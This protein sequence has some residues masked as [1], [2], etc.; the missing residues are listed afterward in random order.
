[1]RHVCKTVSGEERVGNSV[2]GALFRKSRVSFALACSA[3]ALALLAC[4]SDS[5]GNNNTQ[6]PQQDPEKNVEDMHY[7]TVT[8]NTIPDEFS[9]SSK[10]G[11][12][13]DADCLKGTFC[14]HGTCAAQ[15]SESKPCADGGVCASNGICV[16]KNGKRD[17][18]NDAADTTPVEKTIGAEVVTT[19]PSNI[20]VAAGATSVP[21]EVQ[22]AQEVGLVYYTV[23]SSVDAT[24]DDA[25]EI[26]TAEPV[27]DSQTGIAT[28]TF[29][30]TPQDSSLGDVGTPEEV[31]IDT[32]IGSWSLTLSPEIHM[33]GLY[34]GG[35]TAAR[36][37]GTTLPVR[38]AIEVTPKTAKSF[39]EIT[40]MTLYM[41]ISQSDLFSPESPRA[42]ETSWS[43]IEM[44]KSKSNNISGEPSWVATYASNDFVMPGAELLKSADKVN[45]AIRIEI[46]D[47][48]K[49]SNAFIGKIQ[50]TF[51]GIYRVTDEGDTPDW[52]KPQL[53]GDLLL[54]RDSNFD[55]AGTTN[56]IITHIAAKEELRSRDAAPNYVCDD[57][58][59]AT[60]MALADDESCKAI[61]T[62]GGYELAANAQD[63]LISASD[64]IL[65]DDNLISKTIVGLV[66]KKADDISL[67]NGYQSLKDFLAACVQPNGVCAERPELVCAA[68]LLSR[69]YLAAKDTS[70]REDLLNKWYAMLRESYLGPQFAAWQ[71]DVEVRQQWLEGGDE[72]TFLVKVL[73]GWN[74][75]VL[76]GWE[77]DVL[78]AHV[79]VM[80][81]QITQSALEV[82]THV[83][84]SDEVTATREEILA[85]YADA[86]GGLSDAL[87]LGLRRYD[88]LVTKTTKRIEKATEMWPHVFD[89]YV[90]GLVAAD[91]NEKNNVTSLSSAYGKSLYENVSRLKMLGQS[92]DDLVFMRDA[93]VI[94]NTSL[95][96]NDETSGFTQRKAAA[97]KTLNE[98]RDRYT[99]VT[100]DYQNK[101]INSSQIA[102]TLDN[103]IDSLQRELVTL[104]GLPQGCKTATAKNCEPLVDAGFC[105]FDLAWDSDKPGSL[106]RDIADDSSLAKDL[107]ALSKD[108]YDIY[109]LTNSSEAATAILAYRAAI[110]DVDVARADYQALE[111]KV[112]TL[113]AAAQ[114]YS[115]NLEKWNEKR[116]ELIR[117]IHANIQT[118][119]EH[120]D[121][122]TQAEQDKLKQELANMQSIYD[123][124]AAN[125]TKWEEL[126]STYQTEQTRLINKIA[127][128]ESSA[129][130]M[131]FAGDLAKNV[132]DS[133]AEGFDEEAKWGDFPSITSSLKAGVSMVGTIAWGAFGAIA[134][135]CEIAA[136]QYQASSDIKSLKFELTTEAND[137]KMELEIAELELN[138]QKSFSELTDCAASE[139][140]RES[141]CKVVKTCECSEGVDTS[142]FHEKYCPEHPIEGDTTKTCAVE[143]KWYKMGLDQWIISEQ[144][145][146]DT[147]DQVNDYMRQLFDVNDRYE[148]D[149]QSL[150]DRRVEYLNMAED[151]L[152]KRQLIYKAQVAQYQALKQYYVITQRAQLLKSQYQ[153]AKDRKQRIEN[154]Y[155]TP[156][157]IFAYASDLEVVEAKLELAKE[158]IYDYLAAAEYY[159]VRPFVDLRR[160]TY[161][162]RSA[163]D[164]EKIIDQVDT[165][166]TKCGGNVSTEHVDVSVRQMMGITSELGDMKLGERF[167]QALVEGNVPVNSLTRYTVDTD[168]RTLLKR[169]KDLRSSTFEVAIAS[170][171]NLAATCNAKIDSIAVKLVGENLIKEGKGDVL[172]PTITLFYNGQSQLI[173]CQPNIESLTAI[174]GAKTSYGKY[175]TFITDSNKISPKSGLNSFGEKNNHLKGLPLATTYTVLIDTALS[176]NVNV[177]WDNVE[178]VII[179]FNYTYQDLFTSSHACVNL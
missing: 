123:K 107:E 63:C 166:T 23:A 14:Y 21:V 25:L 96:P 177:N 84:S 27:V 117:Q 86:W 48:D 118:I 127:D 175:S 133:L 35:V 46:F 6:D 61:T 26:K 82:L 50:D 38:M 11:C 122:I 9:V 45:R 47:F 72:P 94:V 139:D 83:E 146:V 34:N 55:T 62:L 43:K 163:N 160:A 151:L 7:R 59:L 66:S 56:R 170:F 168:V 108:A 32:S 135:G 155:F 95:D 112:N 15:C 44:K 124:Q 29:D 165:I 114:A 121:N 172:S 90:S 116:N 126:K 42:G 51:A 54:F 125:N 102:A 71:R 81:R 138:L 73:E 67:V 120:Y 37:G 10:G 5:K 157:S 129:T 12:L 130:A 148:R 74:E 158:R 2:R 89:L 77:N 115:D 150:D 169:S 98:A 88:A 101:Q 145:A 1:M 97:Q 30:V 113:R 141:E 131:S 153:A 176:E 134:T 17:L 178:D 136:Q 144:N 91:I 13:I 20:N 93:E 3:L 49:T 65:D 60:L 16:S 111:N 69:S 78:A 104:C 85:D 142:V 39:E 106:I 154:L 4:S 105:G 156:A 109:S 137:R 173:S 167:R 24:D 128:L 92:F 140:K 68:D 87:S 171:S 164:L 152:S 28:Y 18:D 79:G 40:A 179:Q 143:E 41:P 8:D 103:N 31:K 161:L 110:A 100:E 64:A 58:S 76:T 147:I 52:A 53:T 33:N 174:Y 119:N 22:V 57:K 19:A 36:F 80:N 70:V 75:E 162:A 159:A 132:A 149:K 99:K